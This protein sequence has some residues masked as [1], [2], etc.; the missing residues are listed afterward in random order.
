[1]PGL[2]PCQ[3]KPGA[4]LQVT[5]L[6]KALKIRPGLPE[7]LPTRALLDAPV[8]GWFNAAFVPGSAEG[9]LE[10]ICRQAYYQLDARSFMIGGAVLDQTKNALVRIEAGAAASVTPLPTF[11]QLEDVR[12]FPYAGGLYLFAVGYR[13]S[14]EGPQAAPVIGKV[15]RGEDGLVLERRFATEAVQGVEKNWVFFQAAGRLHIEKFPGMAE[16]YEVDPASLALTYAKTA[17][18]AFDWSG[19]KAVSLADGTSLF[20]D[21][22]RVYIL[23]GLKTVQRYIYRFRRAARAGGPAEVSAIF[24]LGR[25]E[26][27]TYV[28][29]M[30]LTP[31][32]AS[33]L[34]AAS[35]DD[36]SFEILSTPLPEVMAR[37]A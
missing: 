31:D 16:L 2:G 8:E 25:A 7:R 24:S 13:P 12:L 10:L 28:S 22:K 20:L 32:G 35:Y 30:A 29:D 14:S 19:T 18:L 5:K 11:D 15:R 17:E 37:L 34:I 4:R 9:R 21:H 26:R 1:M 27:L 6:K 36:N 3:H 23:R 33:L